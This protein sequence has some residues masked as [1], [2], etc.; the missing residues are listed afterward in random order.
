MAKIKQYLMPMP[1]EDIIFRSDKIRAILRA[2]D[3]KLYYIRYTDLESPFTYWKANM[4]EPAEGISAFKDFN[5]FHRINLLT[6]E[7]FPTLAEVLSQIP[8]SLIDQVLAFELLPENKTKATLKEEDEAVNN[9]YQVR[10]V[11]LYR[12]EH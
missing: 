5:T 2:S 9:G 12:R 6:N 10:T 4:R 11:R 8:R 1:R 3:E 7:C